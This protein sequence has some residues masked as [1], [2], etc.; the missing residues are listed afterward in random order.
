MGRQ[1]DAPTT[2]NPE[3][4]GM[5]GINNHIEGGETTDNYDV[6]DG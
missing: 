4:P 1:A 5:V 6:E 2:E 3:E